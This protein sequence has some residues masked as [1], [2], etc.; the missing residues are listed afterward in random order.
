[1]EVFR[2][3]IFILSLVAIFYVDLRHMIIPD[4]ITIP[5]ITLA[6]MLNLMIGDLSALTMAGGAVA[7]GGFFLAQFLIS[8][9]EW[10]GGGDIRLGVLMGLMLGLDAGLAALFLAYLIGATV[11]VVLLAMGRVDRKT[12]LPFGTF[13]VMGTLIMLLTGNAP[14]D[15]YLGFLLR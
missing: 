1:M 5:A 3:S 12:P 10:I 4:K 9:G 8:K 13:L 2:T 6:I 15:W 11:S 14:L 7:I